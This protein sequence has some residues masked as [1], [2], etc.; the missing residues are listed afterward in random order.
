M[1]YLAG[2]SAC[3]LTSVKQAPVLGEYEQTKEDE[4]SVVAARTLPALPALVTDALRPLPTAPLEFLLQR[5]VDS[6]LARHPRLLDRVDGEGPRRFGIEPLDLPFA[7]VIETHRGAARLR[8]VSQLDGQQVDARIAGNL[9]ALLD[10]V[11]G[12]HDG[13]ALFFSR[14]LLVEGDIEAV[15]AL[16][17]AIDNAE[18]DLLDEAAQLVAERAV[19][20]A[21]GA[22][23]MV[24]VAFPGGLLERAR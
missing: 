24:A 16:R 10:L 21:A 3:A 8:V 17:N 12:R 18:L 19:R 6:I 14:D 22:L 9:L 20:A 2:R 5:L 7:M 23:A 11:N 1:Q 13:D 4:R 15:L